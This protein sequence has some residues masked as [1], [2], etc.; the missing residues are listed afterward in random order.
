MS[1]FGSSHPLALSW[2][3]QDILIVAVLL[4]PGASF[5]QSSAS[6][7]QSLHAGWQMGPV[8]LHTE[9]HQSFG[10]HNLGNTGY[11]HA[12]TVQSAFRGPWELEVKASRAHVIMD[13]G[14]LRG[15][16]TEIQSGSVMVNWVWDAAGTRKD[17]YTRSARIGKGFQPFIG[18]GLA[19]VDHLMKQDLEDAFGRTYHL[20]SDGTLR[21]RDE[22]GD[23]DG[24]A[25]VLRRDYTYESD[26]TGS[27]FGPTSGRSLAIPAQLGVRLDV[28]P[29]IRTRIGI[30][31]WLG[32]TDQIDG[33]TG[34]Q[35]LSGDALASGFFGLAIRLG[36]LAPKKSL[37]ATLPG[38][39]QEDAVL[40]AEMDT[41]GDGVSNL[42]DRCP[43]TRGIAVDEMGCPRDTDGDGYADY[44]DQELHSPHWNVDAF[45]VAIDESTEN[46]TA[47]KSDWD[48]I[49]GKVTSDDPTTYVVRV[50]KPEEG[51]TYAERQTLMEFDRLKESNNAVDVLTGPAA[52]RAEQVADKIRSTGLSASV[53]S[54]QVPLENVPESASAPQDHHYR[55]QLGAYRMPDEQA[56]K[57][58]FDG[59]DIVR[60]ESEDGWTRI[61]SPS[62]ATKVEALDYVES[63][64]SLG[65]S[66]SFI[67]YN[68]PDAPVTPASEMAQEE[69]LG[70]PQFDADKVTFRV[71]MAALQT[72]MDVDA[73][74][75]LLNMGS[76]DHHNNMG[77]HRYLHGA[78]SSA[79]EA[80]SA[81]PALR[82]AGFPDAFIV[83][84]VAGSI[85]PAA[86]AELL[87]RNPEH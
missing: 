76:I 72:Q 27:D 38:I 51:W 37:P 45:G 35:W 9:R 21:D 59:M 34:G 63:S 86:E 32:L 33:R 69:S 22:S 55:V 4:L 71:Q 62:F 26:V 73:L 2:K 80:R 24:N 79:S 18:V 7:E 43:G 12:L 25:T 3:L 31:G 11:G 84:D 49:R 28:S 83:G 10:V 77:W 87:L 74:N 53:V 57:V 40:L 41:D 42:H 13:D 44:R 65:F 6:T 1:Y 64:K 23:H 68:H 39:S 60:F 50:P 17:A 85:V 8:A 20:W 78:F 5:G 30:G 52:E 19:H 15:W 46:E 48:V 54:P 56:L 67:L 36:K 58:L 82:A 16:K 66:G 75:Q 29:R 61:V 70:A 81:L 14:A 47:S